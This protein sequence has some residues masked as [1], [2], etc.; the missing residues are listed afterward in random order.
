[1]F[2]K[3]FDIVINYVIYVLQHYVRLLTIIS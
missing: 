3:T 2:C 1:L